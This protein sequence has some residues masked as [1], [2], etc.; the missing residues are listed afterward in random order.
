M[1]SLFP[2]LL[3]V[4]LALAPEAGS[5]CSLCLASQSAETRYAFLWTTGFLSVLPL[6]MVGLAVWWVRRRAREQS[7]RESAREATAR[8]A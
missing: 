1:R 2:A 6:G 7:Q 4:V 5:A 3:L 8:A